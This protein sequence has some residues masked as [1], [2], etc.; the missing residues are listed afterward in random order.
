MGCDS[1]HPM[2]LCKQEN[3]GRCMEA[4]VSE[5]DGLEENIEP[6][7]DGRHWI[8]NLNG[9]R[10][11]GFKTKEKARRFLDYVDDRPWFAVVNGVRIGGFKTEAEARRFFDSEL[12]AMLGRDVIAELEVGFDNVQRNKKTASSD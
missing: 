7:A 5:I 3:V 2:V 10:I 8:A 11:G 12:A 6:D 4:A 9:D 1:A